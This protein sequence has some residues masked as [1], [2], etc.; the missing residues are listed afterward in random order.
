MTKMAENKTYLCID[1]KSFFASV[2]CVERGLDPLCTNLVVADAALTEKTICLA[3]SPSLKKYGI[4]G[5]ARLFEVVQM[6][7]QANARRRFQAPKRLF[8]GSSSNAKELDLHHEYQIDYIIAPPRM[9]KYMEYSTKIYNIY[10]KYVAPEDIHAY[11]IDEVFVDI[12]QYLILTGLNA[13]EFAGQMIKD[14]LKT[15]GITATA[16]IGTNLYLAKIAMD[17][18]AKHIKADSD[19]VRIAMLTEKSYRQKLWDH[20]PLTDFWRIGPKTAKKLEQNG[21]FTMGD[22]ARCSVGKINQFH[23]EELLYRLFG[24][25]A[26]LIID[27]AWGW[28]P[29]TIAHIKAYRPQSSSIENGQVLHCP[30]TAEKTRLIVKEMTDQLLL[31]LVDKGLVTDQMV[32]KI[33]YDIENLTDPKRREQYHGDIVTDRYGRKI[34]KSAHGSVNIGRF[35]SSAKLATETVLKLYDT[36]IDQNLLVRRL[37]LTANHVVPE[38]SEPTRKKPQQLD[39]FTDYKALEKKEQEEKAA[40]DKEKKMQ[41]AMLQIKKKFGKNAI[42]KGMNLLDGATAK[43]RNEQIGGHKA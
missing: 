4:G 18:E 32:L 22:V 34:P 31:Q 2:E 17:I 15:T 27:H 20:R 19:G 42:L 30:Y 5:R 9:A 12:T 8:E 3:V 23:N 29:C 21:M 24:I 28:E 38:G 11:S 35:T 10:L 13:Y 1:L 37:S 16:G 40:L 26:E 39:L 25:N 14:V 33:G 41:Q 6:V 36:I 43:E 7:K